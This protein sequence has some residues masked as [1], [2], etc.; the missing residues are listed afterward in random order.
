VSVFEQI[1]LV[2]IV[3]FCCAIFA[4][5]Y[6]YINHKEKYLNESISKKDF[7]KVKKFD[8]E[9][10]DEKISEEKIHW[11]CNLGK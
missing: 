2:I 10:P 4:I 11:S 8:W 5:I 9:I 3:V 6:F 1:I 7:L